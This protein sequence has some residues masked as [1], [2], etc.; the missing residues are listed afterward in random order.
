MDITETYY[1]KDRNN[2]RKWLSKNH[3]KKTE[4][5]LIYYKK[6]TGK[7]RVAYNDA[8]EEALCFGWIDS[9]IKK[10]DEDK[11]CQ[12]FSVRNEK[13]EWSKLNKK[14]VDELIKNKLM[15]EHGLEKV[16]IAKKNGMWNKISSGDIQYEMPELF[17]KELNKN[18]K[19]KKYFSNLA[20]S[21][22]K[23]YIRWIAS[24]KRD[25]TKL[26]RIAK[27]ITMLEENQKIGM[28]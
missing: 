8:V 15:T 17:L 4:I 11:Y 18:K 3:N 1:A 7:S 24:A 27:A 19:A 22:K 5:W 16:K 26:N 14:R 28:I 9:T 6:H 23:N 21:H 2:W 25:E 10:V 13:S 20:P 12:R